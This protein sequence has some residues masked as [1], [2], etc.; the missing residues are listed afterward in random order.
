MPLPP[1]VRT[2]PWLLVVAAFAATAL[3]RP[4]A[5]VSAPLSA[6][7]AG[8][9][10]MLTRDAAHF[11]LVLIYHGPQDK[12]FYRLELH[13]G[14]AALPGEPFTLRS[15]ITEAQATA[16]I[17]RL[18]VDGC[19]DAALDLNRN[20]SPAAPDGPYYGLML[21]VDNGGSPDGVDEWLPLDQPT[22]AKRIDALRAV[23]EGEPRR[24]LDTLAT[25]LGLPVPPAAAAPAGQAR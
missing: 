14:D 20:G 22:L 12:P 13:A 1:V 2:L 15:K 21:R 4:Q 25:R 17:E 19:L 10:A 8:R 11:S 16:V 5:A 9:A 6:K 23:L 24:N 18:A 3:L 7:A